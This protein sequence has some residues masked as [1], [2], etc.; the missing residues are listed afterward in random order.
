MSSDDFDES[1]DQYKQALAELEAQIEKLGLRIRYRTVDDGV[2]ASVYRW[3]VFDG[4]SGHSHNRLLAL[5]EA[6]R[7]MRAREADV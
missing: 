5:Q 4:F 6:R 1:S 3:D 7:K 2:R